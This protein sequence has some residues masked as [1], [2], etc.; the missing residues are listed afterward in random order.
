MVLKLQ[1]CTCISAGC[2]KMTNCNP[3]TGQAVTGFYVA[4]SVYKTH[5]RN[6]KQLSLLGATPSCHSEV[7]ALHM[8]KPPGA[9]RDQTVLSNSDKLTGTLAA[10]YCAMELGALDLQ[11]VISN[12][13]SLKI[14]KIP[15]QLWTP[16]PSLHLPVGNGLPT[17]SFSPVK[18]EIIILVSD[19]DIIQTYGDQELEERRTS[20]ITKLSDQQAFLDGIIAEQWQWQ[21]VKNGLIPTGDQLHIIQTGVA[22]FW[23]AL[24]F[25]SQCFL[26]DPHFQSHITRCQLSSV[27]SAS[28]FYFL[29][30]TQLFMLP[31]DSVHFA[32]WPMVFRGYPQLH[33]LLLRQDSIHFAHCYPQFHLLL[34]ILEPFQFALHTFSLTSIMPGEHLVHPLT[35]AMGLVPLAALKGLEPSKVILDILFILQAGMLIKS[36][37]TLPSVVSTSIMLYS[38]PG[39]YNDLFNESAITTFLQTMHA[40]F[41]EVDPTCYSMAA[42]KWGRRTFCWR[43]TYQLTIFCVPSE[44][45]LQSLTLGTSG[46]KL[47]LFEHSLPFLISLCASHPHLIMG[48]A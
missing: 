17:W 46:L 47:W 24:H 25:V 33:L 13:N 10:E 19:A 38:L 27:R 26:P 4:P 32:H 21:K 5:G 8:H 3:F 2:S 41:T 29:K 6:D 35:S 11:G 14:S 30:E 36:S 48:E 7:K 37:H 22:N 15:A 44:I 42:N 39:V 18:D 31:T 43:S 1:L 16:L 34:P 40:G 45:F 12:Q 9:Q 23:A 28:I 20:L